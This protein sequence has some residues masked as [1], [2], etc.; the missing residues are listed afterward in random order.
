MIYKQSHRVIDA[1]GID[2]L[3]YDRIVLGSDEILNILHPIHDPIY[4]GV[5]IKS[6]KFLYAPSSGQTSVNTKLPKKC[7]DSLNE[8]IGLSARD[9]HTKELIE[10]NTG[11]EVPLVFLRS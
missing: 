1:S 3:G 8:C 10:N 2:A 5:G 6:A 4:F 11:K 7:V 9:K